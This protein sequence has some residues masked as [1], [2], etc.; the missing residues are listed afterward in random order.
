MIERS[1][2]MVEGEWLEQVAELNIDQEMKDRFKKRKS[3]DPLLDHAL[4]LAS[5]GWLIIPT[6]GKVPCGNEWHRHATN[7]MG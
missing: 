5:H 3:T 1:R 6:L 7:L 2:D 4:A